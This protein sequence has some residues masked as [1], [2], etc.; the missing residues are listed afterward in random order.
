MIEGEVCDEMGPR[1]ESAEGYKLVMCGCRGVD[2]E[3]SL[4]GRRPV[5]LTL[6]GGHV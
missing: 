5:R 6:I 3:R 1:D 2:G 4:R